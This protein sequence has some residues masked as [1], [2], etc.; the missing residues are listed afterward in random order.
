MRKRVSSQGAQ[1]YVD[2][3]RLLDGMGVPGDASLRICALAQ[4][5]GLFRE[6][7][8]QFYDDITD[9]LCKELKVWW[10]PSTFRNNI[11]EV[12]SR[13]PRPFWT[14]LTQVKVFVI[15]YSMIYNKI[16]AVAIQETGL[17]LT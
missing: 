6:D 9:L 12:V 17:R 11:L 10:N 14:D 1:W 13:Y 7:E 2:I 15:Q 8:S 5:Y 3:D 16:Q 4:E